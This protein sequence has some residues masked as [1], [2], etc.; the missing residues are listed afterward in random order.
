MDVEL[1]YFDVQGRATQI[2]I[3]LKIAGIEFTDTRLTKAAYAEVSFQ[4][5]G[6]SH[7]LMI[8]FFDNLFRE[9]LHLKNVPL[10]KYP[11]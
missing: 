4:D 5:D 2:R 9:N 7:N 3:M 11:F 6:S 8:T 10:V 1:V